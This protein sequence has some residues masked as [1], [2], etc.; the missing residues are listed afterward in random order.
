[1]Q[2][3]Q[4]RVRM[5]MVGG[6][7]GAFIG[8]VHRMAAALDGEIDLVCG[9][10]SS[11]PERAQAFG[12]Q[13][14]LAAERCY[15]SFEA[16]FTAESALPAPQRMEFVVIVTPNDLHY[17]V[18]RMALAHGFHVLC[19]KPAT[20]SLAECQ[21]LA[22]QLQDSPCLYAL[23]H[24]Y[25]GYPMVQEARALVAQ[26][27][28]GRVRKVVAEYSQGWLA[29]AQE[30]SQKQAAWRLDPTRAG[31][32]CCMGD[33]GVH[34]A[35]LVEFV[36]GQTVSAVC[37]ELHSV[38]P[39]RLLDDDGTVLF[40]MDGGAHGVLLASQIS[41]GEENN[42]RL[43]V[44]GERASL[45]W[46]QQEPNSLWLRPHDDHAHCLRVGVGSLSAATR[47][48]SRLPAGHPEGYLEAFA[49]IYRNFASAVRARRVGQ[50]DTPP[51][52]SG[53]A[54][55][56]RGMAFI[57]GVVQAHQSGAKWQLIPQ[58]PETSL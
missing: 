57:E 30:S 13:L 3:R 28:L 35:S 4:Q 6:G 36:T 40:R 55:A 12:R 20:H 25:L 41:V 46:Q 8:A 5:G 47:A 49:N 51:M 31:A 22:L 48:H 39:G 33:I 15:G 24:T 2:Q 23:T 50:G 56:L 45:D 9:A 7:E 38:V 17:P 44:Y 18:A 52:L 16:M 58:M 42:L 21:A 14:G 11:Q 10:F 19:D 29:Q 32:S 37:A 54:D 43:R 27:R 53:I 26:G 1:M 34:A